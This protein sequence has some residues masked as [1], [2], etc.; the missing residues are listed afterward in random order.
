MDNSTHM[1]YPYQTKGKTKQY[2]PVT[3][4]I[5]VLFLL[6]ERQLIFFHNSIRKNPV[7]TFLNQ[8][9]P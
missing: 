1:M 4:Q 2:V 9:V 5:S 8:I 7:K 6:N 3:A